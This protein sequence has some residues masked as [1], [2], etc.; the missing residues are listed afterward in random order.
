M[1]LTQQNA[2][3]PQAT[4]NHIKYTHVYV[5]TGTVSQAQLQYTS[6]LHTGW[7][8][9]GYRSWR[10]HG[11]MTAFQSSSFSFATGSLHRAIVWSPVTNTGTMSQA[12]KTLTDYHAVTISLQ[13]LNSSMNSLCLC[14]HH[15]GAGL[16]QWSLNLTYDITTQ[17]KSRK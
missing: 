3:E 16:Q 7:S 11:Q 8:S 1:H 14:H 12:T 2:V 15:R 4:E 17:N 6:M 5:Y 9:T 13:P 10:W